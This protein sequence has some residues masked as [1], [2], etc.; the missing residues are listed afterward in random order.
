MG[1]QAHKPRGKTAREICYDYV[2][3]RFEFLVYDLFCF[4]QEQEQPGQPG[5][6]PQHLLQ[7]AHNMS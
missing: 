1:I 5:Q 4:E 2:C 6:A 7:Q 3:C